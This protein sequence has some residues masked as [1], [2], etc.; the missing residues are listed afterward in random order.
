MKILKVKAFNINSLKGETVIDFESF[1]K[2]D[3]LFAITGPT[4]AGKSTIL[5]IITCALYGRTARLSSPPNELMTQN[6]AECYC[7]VEFEIKGKSYRSSWSQRRARNLVDGKLQTAKMEIALL[8]DNIIISSNSKEVSQ[9]VEALSGLDFD[10][11][12]QS[13]M[14]AQGGFDAFLKAKESERSLL[15]EKITGTQIYA[16]VSKEIYEKHS[17]FKKEIE[18][19]ESVLGVIEVFSREERCKRKEELHEKIKEKNLAN[20]RNKRLE[21]EYLWLNKL[22]ELE[23]S[24]RTN[25]KAFEQSK[26]KR[27]R[28][29]KL[30]ISLK[31]AQKAL[32]MEALYEK[33]VSLFS[34]IE[35]NDRDAKKSQSE[36][37]ELKVQLHNKA[38]ELEF[39]RKML[40]DS[41]KE[42]VQESK[43]IKQLRTILF[44]QETID[45][46]LK[47]LSKIVVSQTND[48][49]IGSIKLESTSTSFKI[50][51][52]QNK[53][54]LSKDESY[55]QQYLELDRISRED[56]QRKYPLS[57]RLKHLD[58]LIGDAKQYEKI[59]D[60]QQKI[61]ESLVAFKN[62]RTALKNRIVE[63]EQLITEV[64]AHLGSLGLLKE[65]ELLIAK[66]EEDRESL[67]TG[68]ACFLCGS[69][70][71]PYLENKPKIDTLTASKIEERG[72]HLKNLMLELKLLEKKHIQ[73]ISKIESTTLEFDKLEEIRVELEKNLK[74]SSIKILEEE[75]HVT[76]N[77][78]NEIEDR[79]NRKI[80][81]LE[82]KKEFENSK[83]ETSEN[84]HREELLIKE[85][86]VRIEAVKKAFV[87]NK[88]HQKE[89][90]EEYLI[91]KKQAIL[92][93]NVDGGIEKYEKESISKRDVAKEKFHQQEKKYEIF[94]V[95]EKNSS[96]KLKFLSKLLNQ[97]KEHFNQLDKTFLLELKENG[98]KSEKAFKEAVLGKERRVELSK[99][100]SGMEKEYTQYQTLYSDTKR[101]LLEHKKE[102]FSNTSVGEIEESLKALEH[103]IDEI[104]KEIGSQQKEL[105]IDA[106]NREKHEKKIEILMQKKEAFE[107]WVK[108]NEMVG[109]AD[110]AKFS[111]FAQ[112]ITLDQL[113]Y[114]ANSQLKIL[115]IRYELCRSRKNRELLGIE[116]VDSF[117]GNVVR[118]VSTLSGGESFIVSLSLAL[119]LSSLAS[120]K[121]SIDSL[122]LDEGFGTL[123]EASLETALNA[124]SLLQ[125][126]GKMI[127]LIS[128]VEALKERIPLQIKIVPK[129]DGTSQVLM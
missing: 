59:V 31:L 128:H 79:K 48:V 96:E 49:K 83:K 50:L 111:K 6:T 12:K 13:M 9:K 110:G 127:G 90:Q 95:K 39:S 62:N 82:E 106:N 24:Y 7:E 70:T 4:G 14:L 71:H 112:G 8:S 124:L 69:T 23:R 108:L 3:A 67:S 57:A 77:S 86:E 75:Y 27:E 92:T 45:K 107:V 52:E 21:K 66:Y 11:F 38:L 2:N 73:V 16:E 104:Q 117:Q 93:L 97:N 122:F 60:N 42:Y 125:S 40:F 103:I 15:L 44:K 87:K 98:F 35:K 29:Q 105:E 129:G 81:L 58:E 34:D 5:D 101:Q 10:K 120:Q 20:Q 33:R 53:A 113:I 74:Q 56:S 115:S 123:D 18:L 30:F 114:L 126:K 28:Y 43:K 41:Q 78:L 121:I 25:S 46:R 119:G 109:S 76:Q 63:K 37:K 80:K 64:K 72:T 22:I 88:H 91:L 17:K 32:N 65:Q 84:L 51:N 26:D 94:F 47:E 102:I 118:S 1:L 55:E 116:V 36:Q 89:L 85:L 100:C 61:D 99:L 54:F 68:E 19:E